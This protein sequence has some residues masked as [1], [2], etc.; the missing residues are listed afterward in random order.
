MGR[1]LAGKPL[2]LHLQEIYGRNHAKS[3]IPYKSITCYLF[4]NPAV[5]FSRQPA[6]RLLSE[7][8]L[9]HDLAAR[10]AGPGAIRR[11]YPLLLQ[12]QRVSNLPCGEH[13][14]NSGIALQPAWNKALRIR[15]DL[16]NASCHGFAVALTAS[17]QPSTGVIP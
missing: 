3:L 1:Q 8:Q 15:H 9:A 5:C 12:Q 7:R 6:E 2:S 14:E 16:C 11:G 4:P 10:A 17:F 13:G